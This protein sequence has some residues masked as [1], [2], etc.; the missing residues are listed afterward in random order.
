MQSLDQRHYL[1]EIAYMFSRF[2]HA[3]VHLHVIWGLF[4]SNAHNRL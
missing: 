2:Q 3:D 1:R 4:R